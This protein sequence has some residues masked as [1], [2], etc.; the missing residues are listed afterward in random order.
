MIKIFNRY[1]IQYIL[2]SSLMV[3]AVM[4]ALIFFVTL[5][6][7]VQDIGRGE[8]NFAQAIIYVA[9]RMPHNLYLFS[10]MLIMLGGIIGLGMLTA[11]QELMIIRSAGFSLARIMKAMMYSALLLVLFMML[12][13]EGIAPSLDHK[14][15]IR[16]QNAK[17][18]G[19]AVVT[20]SGMW[21]HEG[22]DFFHIDRVV[23]RHHLEGVTRYQFGADHQL[24]A[25]YHANAM[26]LQEG[27]W[28]LRDVEKTNFLSKNNTQSVIVA[29]DIW[30]FTLNPSLLNIGIV[31]PEEM[32]LIKL[33]KFS[34][35]LVANGLQAG[36]FKLAFWQRLMQPLAIIIMLF[37]A[38]PFVLSAPRS[39]MLGLRILLGI[40]MGFI[41]YLCNAFL[42]QLSIIFQFPPFLAASL[43]ILLF[44][45]LGFAVIKRVR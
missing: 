1:I 11:H 28:V 8:Y 29:Q 25:T 42:G 32:S 23:G 40:V 31:E 39:T 19:Q 9:L 37:L 14:A 16:K 2:T 33:S 41:F 13:G 5:L 44:A 3:L 35:H 43:P 36:Q 10:P 21:L 45:G 12:I 20:I 34:N 26:D 4:F 30:N 18:N 7:E 15:A 6:G 27:K 17:N 38:V 22:N 24:I